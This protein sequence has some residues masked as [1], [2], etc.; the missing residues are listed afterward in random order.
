V[1]LTVTASATA[2]KSGKPIEKIGAARPRSGWRGSS[3]SDVMSSI[4]SVDAPAEDYMSPP[5]IGMGVVVP[6]TAVDG[7]TIIVGLPPAQ[8]H[9]SPP[10]AYPPPL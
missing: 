5:G 8:S 10:V 1:R 3:G 2:A 7:A 4:L 6:G 9:D